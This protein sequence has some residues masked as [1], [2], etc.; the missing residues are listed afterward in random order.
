MR[1]FTFL[2]FFVTCLSL[3]ATEARADL[4]ITPKRIVFQARDRSASVELIN[5]TDHANTYRISWSLMKATADGK[6]VLAPAIRESDQ[7]PHSV[8]NM[9]IFSP[10]QVTIEPHGNQTIRLSLR[11]PADLP[12]GEYRAHLTLTRLAHED[13]PSNDPHAKT[14][15]MSLKVNLSF[16]IPVIVRQGEDKN[17][18]VSL[19]NPQLALQGGR[20]VLKVDLNRDAGVFSSYGNIHVFWKPASGSEKEIGTLNNVALYPELKTR[21]II[22]PLLTKDNITSGAIRVAYTGALESEGTTWA[23]KSFLVGK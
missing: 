14:I 17:L 15:S 6:Y 13:P 3:V 18:K 9:V 22:I 10:R 11:R 4:T 2:A 19:S 7:D 16:S 5:I 23:E 12:P 21:N 1:L 20:A 8:I